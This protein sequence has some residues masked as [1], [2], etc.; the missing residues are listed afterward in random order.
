MTRSDAAKVIADACPD[1][2]YRDVL[3]Q[4][5]ATDVRVFRQAWRAAYR[6]TKRVGGDHK[7]VLAAR[8][9]LHPRRAW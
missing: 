8:D 7:A 5:I 6:E 4:V 2:K 1:I 9:T 3:A